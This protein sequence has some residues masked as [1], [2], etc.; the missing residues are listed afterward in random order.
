MPLDYLSYF[1][2]VLT[3]IHGKFAIY[4]ADYSIHSNFS[5]YSEVI[6]YMEV[7]HLSKQKCNK[8]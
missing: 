4:Q 6:H 1:A 2:L 7:Q 3:G 8:D 5:P